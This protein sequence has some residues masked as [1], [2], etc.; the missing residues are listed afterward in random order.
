MNEKSSPRLLTLDFDLLGDDAKLLDAAVGAGADGGHGAHSGRRGHAEQAG[1]H[2]R[3]HCA[4]LEQSLLT[5]ENRGV[6]VGGG[7]LRQDR[8]LQLDCLRIST[9]AAC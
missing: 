3:R 2:G 6:D 9:T 1:S 5:D 7:R 4:L 8:Q